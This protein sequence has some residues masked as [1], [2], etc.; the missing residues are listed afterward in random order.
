LGIIG[1]IATSI[2]NPSSLGISS[3]NSYKPT[4]TQVATSQ[5]VIIDALEAPS[6]SIFENT[7]SVTKISPTE[8]WRILFPEGCE[9]I[10]DDQAGDKDFD[11]KVAIQARNLEISAPYRWE[12]YRDVP[13]DDPQLLIN[14]LISQG[15]YRGFQVAINNK[16][17]QGIY[18]LIMTKGDPIYQQIAFQWWPATSTELPLFLMIYQGF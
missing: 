11:D 12:L 13:E 6:I 17:S 1:F 10:I 4:S 2:S 18:F 8:T 5:P 9:F 14:Y 16:D 15:N 3:T 7:N